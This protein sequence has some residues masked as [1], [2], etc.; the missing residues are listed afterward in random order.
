MHWRCTAL[1]F[2]AP[3][4]RVLR[5]FGTQPWPP[6]CT[7]P[8]YSR[9]KGYHVINRQYDLLVRWVRFG[10]APPTAPKLEFS[11]DEVPVLVRDELGIV[12]GGIR[13][14]DVEAPTALN[15]G[16]NS[17]ATFCVLYGTYQPFDAATLN[18]LY[19]SHREYVGEVLESARAAQRAGY[20]SRGATLE[21]GLEALFADVP[22]GE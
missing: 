21:Y 8:P 18:G 20:I 14:P 7:L 9:V 10:I 5:D 22:P 2:V 1:G 19:S 3:A 17:G 13:L 6:D 15:T 12:R 16:I 4:A 11:T